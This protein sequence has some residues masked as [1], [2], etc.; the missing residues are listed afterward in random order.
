MIAELRIH[1]CRN[2]FLNNLRPMRCFQD[3]KLF[4]KQK[5]DL[6][7]VLGARLLNSW[8]RG[9]SAQQYCTLRSTTMST[10]SLPFNKKKNS[11]LVSPC[12]NQV[13]G[14]QQYIF[15]LLWPLSCRSKLKQRFIF[16]Q[17]DFCLIFLQI[18]FQV[19]INI[20]KDSQ[21]P[22][23]STMEICI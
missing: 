17:V 11:N 2:F 4:S 18:C 16:F 3:V 5:F 7:I 20:V 21:I 23:K 9:T 19:K 8:W 13:D 6:K 14:R 10:Q 15:Q 12:Y 22:H 1:Y